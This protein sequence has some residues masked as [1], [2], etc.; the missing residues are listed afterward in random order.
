[1]NQ[2]NGAGEI[3][4]GQVREI[5]PEL[6]CREHSLIYDRPRGKACHIAASLVRDGG[7]Q[8]L[9]LD[10]FPDKVEL[11]LQCLPVIAAH[12]ENLPDFRLRLKGI[13]PQ[14]GRVD[15]HL[16]GVH[17][18]ESVGL[19][20]LGYY[21]G[22]PGIVL[23][24][25][26]EEDHSHAVAPLLRHRNSVKE[27]EFVRYLEQDSRSVARLQITALGSPVSH[28]LK[29]GETLL[30]YVMVLASVDVDNQSDAACIVFI[31]R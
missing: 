31:F 21:L 10:G 27:N 4:I 29:D 18:A 25:L 1:M 3:L 17:Y 26:R 7:I 15:R 19:H 9:A 5:I 30:H 13:L 2:G 14:D 6:H 22:E 16:P 8:D 24:I 20:R 11:V 23:R 28:V 12:Y